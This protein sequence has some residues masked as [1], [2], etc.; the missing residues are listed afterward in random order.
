M[1][2][3][4]VALI[5]SNLETSLNFYVEFLGLKVK[6]EF[7]LNEAESRALFNVSSPARAIQLIMDEGMLELFDFKRGIDR[8]DWFSSPP[9]NGLFHF[10]IQIKLPVDEFIDRAGQGGI[11]V[12][13]IA[14]GGR[15]V[16]FIK[17]PDGVLI[18]V[19]E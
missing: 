8:V 15:Y 1:K 14:R 19:K 4:H 3:D 6:R 13:S 7:E 18:E 17:D 5:V 10:A 2:L 11:P 12:L 16:Y 9:K